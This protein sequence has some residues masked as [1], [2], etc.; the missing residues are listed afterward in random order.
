MPA[1]IST[2]KEAP[3]SRILQGR[4]RLP[5]VPSD[6]QRED[7][8]QARQPREFA[9]NSPCPPW[10]SNAPCGSRRLFVKAFE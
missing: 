5:R 7:P 9:P 10:A 8:T 1:R 6:P 4:S 2:G 3:S